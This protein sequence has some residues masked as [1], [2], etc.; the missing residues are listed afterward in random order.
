M[1]RR[2]TTSLLAALIAVPATLAV[3]APSARAAST[4]PSMSVAPYALLPTKTALWVSVPS[5]TVVTVRHS[6]GS[7]I[8]SS[9]SVTG[10]A[11]LVLWQP[12]GSRSS[13]VVTAPGYAP[14]TVEASTSATSLAGALW[15]MT[16]KRNALPSTYAPSGLQT[17]GSRQLTAS[18]ATAVRQLIAGAAAAGLTTGVNSGYRS[19]A[20]QRALYDQD[21]KQ[22]GQK[23]ADNLVARPGFSEHQLG[24][25]A[26]LTNAPCTNASCT[27]TTATGRWIAANAWR[28]G[29]ILSNAV[30]KTAITGWQSEPWH[31]RYLG[32]PLTA[33]VHARQ[34]VTEEDL[35]GLPAAPTY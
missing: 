2:L 24:L 11:L 25:A 35:F 16:N 18:A 33:Y 3:S 14:S 34:I 4:L 32:T 26:D 31:V 22:Y 6:G 30:G 9:T 27:T 29:F 28:Y 10:H 20:S 15:R 23:V 5:G 12:T 1:K 17:V 7:L 19:Y 21:V 13:Y 8:G